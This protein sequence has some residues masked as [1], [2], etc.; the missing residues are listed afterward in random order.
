MSV[1][2][3]SGSLKFK[4]NERDHNPPHLHV[5]GKGASVRINLLTLDWMDAETEFS[6]ADLRRIKAFVK[7]RQ[8]YFLAEWQ[9]IH[10]DRKDE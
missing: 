6:R 8:D 5:E 3:K 10:E 2:V 9:V 7:E 4:I 1:V